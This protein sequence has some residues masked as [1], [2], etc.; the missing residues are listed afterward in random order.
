MTCISREVF[1]SLAIFSISAREYLI[2]VKL[3]WLD[4]LISYAIVK[5]GAKSIE[6]EVDFSK[7]IALESDISYYV[8]YIEPKY[9]WCDGHSNMVDYNNVKRDENISE[10]EKMYSLGYF[11]LYDSGNIKYTW[12]GDN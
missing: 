8:E 7:H 2:V 1:S 10:D 4:L 9:V 6:Y 11:K 12:K 3:N 5:Y